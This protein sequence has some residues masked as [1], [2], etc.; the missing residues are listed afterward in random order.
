MGTLPLTA[1]KHAEAVNS[2]QASAKHGAQSKSRRRRTG[3]LTN[4]AYSALRELIF[5][6]Q[7]GPSDRLVETELADRLKV[8]R[9]PIREA[10]QKLCS[11]GL[12]VEA[13][14]KGYA[15]AALSPEYI[16]DH[17]AVREVLEGLAARFAATSATEMEIV[18]LGALLDAM[19]RANKA[20]RIDE[21]AQHNAAF[22]QLIAKASRNVVLTDLLTLLQDRLRMLRDFNL[23]VTGRRSEAL[24]DQRRLVNAITARDPEKSERLA[25]SLVAN[26]RQARLAALRKGT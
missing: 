2:D 18:Q 22:Y 16:L 10:L 24:K 19:E 15:V 13:P 8:S 11:E 20:N 3:G 9:T 6:G 23:R 7:L 5:A 14:K 4:E 21:L 26:A 12:V 17:Y 1:Q 25:K